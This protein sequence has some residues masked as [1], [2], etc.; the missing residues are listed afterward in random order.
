MCYT[1]SIK[2]PLYCKNTSKLVN[3]FIFSNLIFN[4]PTLL[5]QYEEQFGPINNSKVN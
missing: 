1:V 2:F 5:Q 4:K 3:F